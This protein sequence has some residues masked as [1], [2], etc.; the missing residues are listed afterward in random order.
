M[1]QIISENF[2]EIFVFLNHYIFLF[3]WRFII[4]VYLTYNNLHIL[5]YAIW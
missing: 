3:L 4:V 5:K 2:R 1:P